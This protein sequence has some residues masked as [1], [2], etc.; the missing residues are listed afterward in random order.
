[1]SAV[2]RDLWPTDLATQ[3]VLTPY[4][5][6]SEQADFLTARMNSVLAGRVQVSNLED[7]VVLGFEVVSPKIDKTVRIFA[8]E[9]QPDNPYP[10][11]IA[12]VLGPLPSYLQPT[13]IVP[14][15]PGLLESIQ[16]TTDRVVENPWVASSPREFTEKLGT[17]LS[18]PE[19]KAAVLSLL[20]QT[21]NHSS[22][23]N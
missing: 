5:I 13:R 21:Q 19:V 10:A 9:H 4:E 15:V 7:R 16:P 22:E 6:L 18:R 14:R 12:I 23:D 11:H 20:K 17:M 2:I 1:M 3:E 8:V